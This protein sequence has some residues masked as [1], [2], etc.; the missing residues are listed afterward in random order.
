MEALKR[1][2]V[3]GTILTLR[4]LDESDTERLL[5]FV[6]GLSVSAR[7]FRFGQGDYDPELDGALRACRLDRA[8]GLHLVVVAPADAGETVVGSARYVIEDDRSSCEFAVVVADQWNHHGVGHQLMD[9]LLDGAKGQG[10]R[11]MVGRVLASNLDMLQFARACGFEVS[12][13]PEGPWLKVASL[14]LQSLA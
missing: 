7:Y 2:N 4:R 13:S 1:W 10:L 14:D 3:D 8:Q 6:R 12:D 11:K 5:A 9:A